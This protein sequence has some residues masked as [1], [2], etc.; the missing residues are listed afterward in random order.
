MTGPGEG[1]PIDSYADQ[2]LVPLGLTPLDLEDLPKEARA[3]R[4]LLSPSFRPQCA[5][6]VRDFGEFAEAELVAGDL[7]D[8][9][10]LYRHPGTP[11]RWREVASLRC[12]TLE[13]FRAEMVEVQPESLG[14]AHDRDPSIVRRGGMIAFG[15]VLWASGY[16]RFEAY[17]DHEIWRENPRHERFFRAVWR[18][19]VDVFRED[20]SRRVLDP[21]FFGDL[22]RQEDDGPS[23][24][25]RRR[26]S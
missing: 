24:R 3:F 10:P 23:P 26:R 17:D 15:E 20:W 9:H 4:S 12:P 21:R 14:D 19:A 22:T 6:T 13:N 18:L 2:F 16:H 5:V 1:R 7:T 25:T 11:S 8:M